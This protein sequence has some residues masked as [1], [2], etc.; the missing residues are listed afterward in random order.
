MGNQESTPTNG[1]PVVE[2]ESSG[3]TQKQKCDHCQKPEM[4]EAGA[5]V[6]L[7]RRH[8]WCEEVSDDTVDKSSAGATISSEERIEESVVIQKAEVGEEI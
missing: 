6:C 2:S 4:G 3:A 8:N 7:D 1:S 5:S